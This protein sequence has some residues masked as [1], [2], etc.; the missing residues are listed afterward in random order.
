MCSAATAVAPSF[1]TPHL[2]LAVGQRHGSSVELSA[3]KLPSASSASPNSVLLSPS[4]Q[5]SALVLADGLAIPVTANNPAVGQTQRLFIPQTVATSNGAIIIAPST[6]LTTNNIWLSGTSSVGVCGGQFVHLTSPTVLNLTETNTRIHQYVSVPLR[7]VSSSCNVVV[8]SQTALNAACSAPS[9]TCSVTTSTSP[10][11]TV[12]NLLQRNATSFERL[13]LR[14][15]SVSHG[16]VTFTEPVCL[17]SVCCLRDSV[18]E[19]PMS[20][21]TPPVNHDE[22]S[23]FDPT[24]REIDAPMLSLLQDSVIP[25]IPTPDPSC[26][27]QE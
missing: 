23:Q 21:S 22:N 25:D 8:D 16:H 20:C 5:S 27:S 10:A 1:T 13:Q 26:S 14:S 7:T 18:A 19:M 17:D 9:D 6:S 11:S 24:S 12:A 3:H 15:T 4:Q 2:G